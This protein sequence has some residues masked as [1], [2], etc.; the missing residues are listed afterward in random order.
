MS[1]GVPRWFAFSGGWCVSDQCCGHDLG[2]HFKFDL[3]CQKSSRRPWIAYHSNNQFQKI[4]RNKNHHA[5]P[6]PQQ[7][8]TTSRNSYFGIWKKVC[9][10]KNWFYLPGDSNKSTLSN[11]LLL[12]LLL[13]LILNNMG[14]IHHFNCKQKKLSHKWK[15][16]LCWSFINIIWNLFSRFN[17]VFRLF[18]SFG[19]KPHLC[20]APKKGHL[21]WKMFKIQLKNSRNS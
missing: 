20:Y 16:V 7:K 5:Q 13:L 19:I 1:W 2:A 15:K 18:H 12:L 21:Q 10:S 6:E 8:K 4:P 9:V 17:V 14:N 3:W 11:P